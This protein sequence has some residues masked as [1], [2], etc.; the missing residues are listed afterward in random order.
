MT[1][2]WH[3]KPTSDNR[4]NIEPVPELQSLRYNEFQ[5]EDL[6][7]EAEQ[8]ITVEGLASDCM[9]LKLTIEPHSAQ[10]FG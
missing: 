3:L 9:E 5:V 7:L 10:R 1:L 4:L 6:F 2:P 8:E